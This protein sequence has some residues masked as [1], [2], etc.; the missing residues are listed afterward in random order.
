MSR[1]PARRATE[2]TVGLLARGSAPVTAFPGLTQWPVAR[3]RRFQ[4]RGQLRVLQGVSRPALPV[5]SF[6]GKRPPVAG[7]RGPWTAF[8][9]AREVHALLARRGKLRENCANQ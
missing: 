8:V 7:N 3:G 5:R 4:L 9:N 6:A 2:P 1:H